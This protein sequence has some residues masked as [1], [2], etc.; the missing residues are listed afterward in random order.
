M[1]HNYITF[2][3]ALRGSPP[4]ARGPS[5]SHRVVTLCARDSGRPAALCASPPP[6]CD[7]ALPAR[8]A[9]ARWLRRA[10]AGVAELQRGARRGVVYRCER[11]FLLR[12]SP[13]EALGR[14]RN[15]GLGAA[16]AG[17]PPRFLTAGSKRPS[18][19]RHGRADLGRRNRSQGEPSTS[20]DF[21]ASEIVGPRAGCLSL[22]VA[23]PPSVARRQ[24]AL[25][26]C[27]QRCR[28]MP[29][30]VRFRTPLESITIVSWRK[31]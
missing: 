14:W 27:N 24:V 7:V 16:R 9:G 25:L 12:C 2:L 8:C 29:S 20:F 10:A 13:T 30:V 3:L 26:Q 31:R 1:P 18:N 22:D 23:M 15:E 17:P 5:R 21:N 19:R 28:W 11:A 4:R 6:W